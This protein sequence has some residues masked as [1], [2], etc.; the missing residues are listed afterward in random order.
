MFTQQH[1]YL[2]SNHKVAK[3]LASKNK[4]NIENEVIYKALNQSL[5][6]MV[7][8]RHKASIIPEIHNRINNI[9]ATVE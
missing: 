6:A 8:L 2:S 7:Y 1:H 4:P 5:N 9:L 3:L